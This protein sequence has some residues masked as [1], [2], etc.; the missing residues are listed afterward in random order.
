MP[1]MTTARVC[2]ITVTMGDKLS[3]QTN[4]VYLIPTKQPISRMLMTLDRM[5]TAPSTEAANE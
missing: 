5:M 4:L 3:K 1:I 2:G